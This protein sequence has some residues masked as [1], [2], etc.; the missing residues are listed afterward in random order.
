MKVTNKGYINF[1]NDYNKKTG[2]MMTASMSFAN[3]KDDSG[4]W[5]NGYINVIAFRD[6][7]QRLENSIGQLVEIE[8]TY[9]LNEYTNQ[10]GKVIKT[11]QII[12]DAFLNG[13]SGKSS[14]YPENEIPPFGGEPM[15]ISDDDLPF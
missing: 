11:P 3:G 5:K 10:Q 6:N 2:T 15:D 12:I 4:N 14:S 1:N 7:I 13:V 8:G 9:R